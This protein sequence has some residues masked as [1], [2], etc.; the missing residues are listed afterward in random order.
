MRPEILNPLFAPVTAIKGVGQRF[1]RLVEKAAGPL[2]V[3]LVWH[4]P[5]G[6]IDRRYAPAL[7]DAVPGEIA[8]LRVVVE[9]HLPPANPRHPY[10]VR[11]TD[12]TGFITLVFF[13]V[14]GD[15]LE[16]ML[17][18]GEE[19]LV[20]GRI[21]EFN[22]LLQMSHPD[23]V[24]APGE[25]E[26]AVEPVYGLTAGLSLKMMRKAVDSALE[27]LPTLPEWLDPAFVE[28]RRF[29]ALARRGAGAAPAGRAGRP[30]RRNISPGSASPMTSSWPTSWRWR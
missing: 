3:D 22:G 9:Q 7:R 13:H 6:L 4:I 18:V 30:W 8:T 1:A 29:P 2:V 14:R 25:I 20:S 12:G 28:R 19:R 5:T 15:W 17:P 23:H 11:C 26:L 16:R 10:R 27:R 24:G 21:E